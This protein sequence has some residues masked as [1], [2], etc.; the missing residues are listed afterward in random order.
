MRTVAFDAKPE[1]RPAG[2][3]FLGIVSMKEDAL[4]RKRVFKTGFL[5]DSWPD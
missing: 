2:R 3:L 1:G 5:A 4:P